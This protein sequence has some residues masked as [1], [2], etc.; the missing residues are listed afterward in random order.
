[1]TWTKRRVLVWRAFSRNAARRELLLL[2]AIVLN[3]LISP[4]NEGAHA[5]CP[6]LRDFALNA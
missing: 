6:P 4:G 3:V 1:L 5:L 2:Q